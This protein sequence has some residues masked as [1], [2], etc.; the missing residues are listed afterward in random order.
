MKRFYREVEIVEHEGG[1]GIALDDKLVR[2]PA[3]QPLILPTRPLAEAVRN[4]WAVQGADINPH[5]MPMMQFAST[6]VDRVAPR[7]ADCVDELVKYGGSDLLCYRASHP[8]ELVA[9][10]ETL[11]QPLLDWATLTF[12]AELV[13]TRGLMPVEQPESA[14]AALKAGVERH[15]DHALAAV[16]VTTGL[17]GSLVIG[18]ALAEGRLS[19]L[20][21]YAISQLDETYQAEVWGLDSEAEARRAAL[22]AEIEAAGRY[23]E[24]VR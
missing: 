8:A 24:L 21:A 22:K 13:V 2:S 23:L 17:A 10:Q 4:E 3:K 5:A 1:H 12:G 18:L 15:H 14:L 19:A 20:E 11:W 16:L 6:A 7:R 9:R